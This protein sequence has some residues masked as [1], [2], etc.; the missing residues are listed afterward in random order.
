MKGG[1]WGGEGGLLVAQVFE[2]HGHD[3]TFDDEYVKGK[4]Y[5]NL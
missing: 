1:A 4:H 3:H 5:D 2:L